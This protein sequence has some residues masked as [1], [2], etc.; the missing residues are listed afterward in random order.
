MKGIGEGFVCVCFKWPG[1]GWRGAR[2][3]LLM[4]LVYAAVIGFIVELPSYQ[5]FCEPLPQREPVFCLH[6]LT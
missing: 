4:V 1:P 2:G 3:G 6:V 5:Q